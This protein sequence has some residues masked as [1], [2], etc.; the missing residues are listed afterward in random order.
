MLYNM[1]VGIAF[2][3]FLSDRYEEAGSW[4]QR[5]L[6]ERPNYPTANRI[7]AASRA[8]AGQSPEARQAMATLR[9][10]DPALCVANLGEVIPVR[11]PE[12]LAMFAEGRRKAGLPE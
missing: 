10:L 1:H 11:R 12:H 9:Q 3:H 8:L 7:L 5:A 6:H 2:A 4:A